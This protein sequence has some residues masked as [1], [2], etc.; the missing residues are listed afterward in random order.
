MVL[1]INTPDNQEEGWR[2]LKYYDRSAIDINIL[3]SSKKLF[4]CET[5]SKLILKFW[6]DEH[7]SVFDKRY[8]VNF[9]DANTFQPG[10]E[11]IL[12]EFGT[13][14]Y[15]MYFKSQEDN[16]FVLGR[17]RKIIPEDLQDKDIPNKIR[18]KVLKEMI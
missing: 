1:I 13:S 5:K 8:N 7:Y 9:M 18:N 14:K 4:E 15:N 11:I 2:L 10:E 16:F 12:P 3:S 6:D 17:A